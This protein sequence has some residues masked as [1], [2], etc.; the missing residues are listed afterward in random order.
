MDNDDLIEIVEKHFGS[1]YSL[2]S[3]GKIMS[4]CCPFCEEKV[5]K[6][7]T[8]RKL[9][10]NVDSNS[11]NKLKWHCF[12]CGSSGKLEYKKKTLYDN[13]KSITALKN[14]V[15]KPNEDEY[16]PNESNMIYIPK[17]PIQ[18]GTEAY[19]YLIK[20]G[21]T[22]EKI[23]Y[24]QLRLGKDQF[25][26]RIIIP[27][28]LYGQNWCDVFQARDYTGYK[29][30]KYLNPAEIDKSKIV[31]NLHRQPKNPEELIIVEGCITAIC[32]GKNCVGM[33]GCHPSESQ[34]EQVLA[35]K[36]KNLICC[37][38]NDEAGNN[39]TKQLIKDIIDKNYKGNLFY[40]NMPK[41]KDAADLG[42]EAF[43]EYV[44]KNKK[45]YN[46]FTFNLNMRLL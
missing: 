44:K 5:G 21:I 22:D 8:D 39:G 30:P 2:S 26:K 25:S 38:D 28:K 45:I 29:Q 34:I 3:N 12:R 31:F 41:G 10:V 42:E 7:K 27:N 32:G 20:R 13:L 14:I 17:A 18:K 4:Y 43:Q 46:E 23:E 6:I 37:L 33:Y 11:P 40:V 19:N 35:I 1:D 36:P 24:Y 9:G 15:A 16:V